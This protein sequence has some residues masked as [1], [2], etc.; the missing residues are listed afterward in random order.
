MVSIKNVC[1]VVLIKGK[2]PETEMCF[3]ERFSVSI[4]LI[5]WQMSTCGSPAR[6]C[7]VVIKREKPLWR[8]LFTVYGN[9][10][11]V[12]HARQISLC[13]HVCCCKYRERVARFINPRKSQKVD[14]M[15]PG[16]SRRTDI[17]L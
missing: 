15:R 10:K 7:F 9:S 3:D 6:K 14:S 8:V 16:K 12:V 2:T 5:G 4:C 1:F 11:S 13:Q 17:K